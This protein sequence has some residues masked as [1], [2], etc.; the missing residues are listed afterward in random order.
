MKLIKEDYF[1]IFS[2]PRSGNTWTVNSLYSYLKA[3][4][5]E[6]APSVYGGDTINL[7]D[8]VQIK[9]AG[10]YDPN[11]IV[12]IKS[13]MYRG[14]FLS[15]N[16]PANK[17]LYVFRDPRDVMISYF[18]YLNK[19]LKKG[20]NEEREFDDKLFTEHLKKHLPD[21]VNHI[22]GWLEL[23]NGE[24]MSIRYEDLQYNY[25]ETLKTI[26]QFLNAKSFMTESEVR[27][28]YK[29]NF[30]GADAHINNVLVGDNSAF[31]RKGIVGDWANYFNDEHKDITKTLAQNILEKYGYET[32]SEW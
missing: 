22:K 24:L 1:Y 30:K 16:I 27:E 20:T 18:F 5:A 13:H 8:D 3:Q 26:K 4:R 12:G 19:F 17:I 29:D 2:F 31:Y 21:L 14:E 10:K 15:K 7:T 9:F 25:E 11:H 23:Y 32:N 6:I 28:L